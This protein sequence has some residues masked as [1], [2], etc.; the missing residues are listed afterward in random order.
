M[1][2]SRNLESKVIIRKFNIVGLY[3]SGF[4]EIDENII[5]GDLKHLKRNQ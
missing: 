4:N 1:I 5:F 2:F 3:D